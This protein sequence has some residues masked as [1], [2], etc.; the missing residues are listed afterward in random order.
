[1]SGRP[2][3]CI[4]ALSN[5][6]VVIPMDTRAKNTSS[7]HRCNSSLSMVLSSASVQI[8]AESDI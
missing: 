3:G 2:S 1:M 6:V 7:T 8:N 4:I 5:H